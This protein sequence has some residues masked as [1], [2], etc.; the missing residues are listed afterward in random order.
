MVRRAG[1]RRGSDDAPV[2]G[3]RHGSDDAP[4]TGERIAAAF[5]R[6]P[7]LVGPLRSAGP[8]A[9]VEDVVREAER[10]TG[11]MS[12]EDLIALLDAHPRI[13]ADPARLSAHSAREQGSDTEAATMRELASLNDEYERRFGFRCVVHVAGRPKRALV[14]VIRE[15]LAHDRGIELEI[16]LREFLAIARDRLAHGRGGQVPDAER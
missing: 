16:G 3:E 12:E 8:Y 9:G 11:G 5:E 1:E 13:G 2:T 6:V 15:R 10:L 7:V 14:P 4:V